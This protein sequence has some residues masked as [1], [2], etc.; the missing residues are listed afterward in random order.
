MKTRVL[1]QGLAICVVIWTVVFAAQAYFRSLR[2]TAESLESVVNEGEFVDWL[3]R[4]GEP[5]PAEAREREKRIE[6]VV[7]GMSKLE[8]AEGARARAMDLKHQLFSKLS[9]GEQAL[10]VDLILKQLDPYLTAFDA[11]PEERREKFLNK[12]LKEAEVEFTPEQG[13]RFKE[14]YDEGT[15][16]KI[17]VAGWREAMKD[18]SPDQIMEHL[19]LIEIAGELL[20]RIRI[21][22]WEG[23]DRDE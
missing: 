2:L 14:L 23:R 12:A 6:R 3:E 10:F 18:K 1:L 19:K 17:A 20:Q 21:P 4:E 7:A 8:F 5:Q 15:R 11:L 22:K 13:A 9:P 16:E